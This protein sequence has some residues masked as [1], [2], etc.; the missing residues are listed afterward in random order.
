MAIRTLAKGTLSTTAITT[1]LTSP[2]STTSSIS[3]AV[4][5][6]GSASVVS[7]EVYVCTPSVDTLAAVVRIPAGVGKSALVRELIGGINSQ[8]SIKLKPSSSSAVNYIIY[9]ETTSS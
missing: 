6:N 5:C 9:G 8:N 2:L 7:V 4:L 3:S 1:V